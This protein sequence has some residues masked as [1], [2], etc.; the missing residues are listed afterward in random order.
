MIVSDSYIHENKTMTAFT[1]NTLLK[2]RYRVSV[3][4]MIV[5]SIFCIIKMI[6]AYRIHYNG[7]LSCYHADLSVPYPFDRNKNDIVKQFTDVIHEYKKE[8]G[9]QISIDRH[10]S[11]F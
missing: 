4:G 10:R 5:N 6:N 8:I 1:M 2:I 7:R 3:I 11:V 9:I